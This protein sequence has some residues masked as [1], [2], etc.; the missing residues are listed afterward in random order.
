M[1]THLLKRIFG[2][3][4]L[5]DMQLL[6]KLI[7]SKLITDFDFYYVW[8]MF[9]INMHGLFLW[10]IEKVLQLCSLI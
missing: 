5:P 9:T 4:Y 3:T 10:T 2:G 1:Y 6:N 8:L 7:L